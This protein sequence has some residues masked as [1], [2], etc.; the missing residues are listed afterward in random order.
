[1]KNKEYI[2]KKIGDFRNS[3]DV[4]DTEEFSQQNMID[5]L[6]EIILFIKKNL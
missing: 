6:D 3:H 4:W 2:I 1:M 5:E